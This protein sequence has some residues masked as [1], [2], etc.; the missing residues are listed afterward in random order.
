MDLFSQSENQAQS[1]QMRPLAHRMRPL[2]LEEFV[3]QTKVL[4]SGRPLAR[5]IEND[6]VPSLILWGPPGCGK[7]TLA[8]L[9]A[10]RTRS[11]YHAL[12]AI[13]AGVKE[14]RETCESARF[15]LRSQNRRTLLFV[16]EIH[17][18][19]K[20]Q[21]DTLLPYVEDGSITLVGATTENPSFEMN[22]ALLSRARVVRFERISAD[23]LVQLL[24]R[25]LSDPERGLGGFLKLSPEAVRYVAE[26]SE[27]DAR[28]ALTLLESIALS[29]G[30]SAEPLNA[31]AIR[32]L[33][34]G[35]GFR[36][37]LPYDKSGEQHYNTISAFIKS[38]RA[39][40]PDAAVYYLARMLESGE[41]PVFVA[42]RMVVFASEDVGNADPRAL[43]MAI[44]ALQAV[45]LIGLPEAR[46]NLAQVVTYLAVAPKS[47]AS[48]DAIGAAVGEVQATGALPV[49]M[50]LRNAV[51]ALM[52]AEGYGK[53]AK[54]GDEGAAVGNLPEDVRTRK[55]YE[56]AD[57]GLEKTIRERMKAVPSAIP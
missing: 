42:R 19:N 10:G 34:Q 8:Q 40:D 24:N 33:V 38:M 50:H 30:H 3:G 1:P 49:P 28:R 54:T 47:R 53:H 31:D 37:P 36:D 13:T 11:A 39:N 45:E 16:D 4:G 21:Q 57:S 43:Q 5:W 46:I 22:S 12:S 27:G 35:A 51:T 29:A 17:R 25:A 2:S 48:Y 14:L 20:S 18:F 32:E 15:L 55:F 6:R 26:L 52:R 44:A 9:I 41:D 23:D 56:P 7:T